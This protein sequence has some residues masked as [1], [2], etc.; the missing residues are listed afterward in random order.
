MHARKWTACL[1]S[2]ATLVTVGACSSAASQP[3]SSGSTAGTAGSG[4]TA[5]AAQTVTVNYGFLPGAIVNIPIDIAMSQGFFAS[6]G[7]KLSETSF[8]QSNAL[9]AALS[10]GQIDVA[11]SI[12]QGMALAKAK[13]ADVVG[14]AA[15]QPR[16][17][18]VIYT[19]DASIPAAGSSGATW[20]DTIKA[21]SGKAIAGGA[22]GGPADL[23]LKYAFTQAGLKPNY[24]IINAGKGATEMAAVKTGQVTAAIGASLEAAIGTSTLGL[25]PVLDLHSQG[26]EEISD[27]GYI[28][29]FTTQQFLNAHPGFAAHFE[30]AIAKAIKYMQD[31]ENL[32]AIVTTMVNDHIV[33]NVTD[34]QAKS[35]VAAQVSRFGSTYTA[36]SVDNSVKFLVAVG[37]LP[38]GTAL[39]SA[40]LMAP[41]ALGEAGANG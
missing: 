36:T 39:T 35:I 6:E 18:L 8:T 17:D 40:Q 25:R 10:S 32:P 12:V 9:V 14:I 4:G 34:S 19:K 15:L 3:A 20:Q 2:L 11:P 16:M 28:G 29:D 38:A 31:P 7:I 24:S 41:S 33:S 30:A 21:L 1:F 22:A 13:G 5:A 23:I 26:P 37:S 27:Q